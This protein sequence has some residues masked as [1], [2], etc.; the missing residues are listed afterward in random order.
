MQRFM[1][2]TWARRR[3]GSR[4]RGEAVV[5]IESDEDQPVIRKDQ[6]LRSPASAVRV[7]IG[8]AIDPSRRARQ[9]LAEIAEHIAADHMPWPHRTEAAAMPTMRR[10]LVLGR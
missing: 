3:P 5:V 8:L 1:A 2:L 10:R 9:R 4:H 7:E 6:P